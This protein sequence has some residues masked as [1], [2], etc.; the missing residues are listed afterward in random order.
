MRSS[1]P[2]WLAPL[3]MIDSVR[4]LVN[5]VNNFLRPHKSVETISVN[6]ERPSYASIGHRLD[7]LKEQRTSANAQLMTQYIVTSKV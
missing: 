6:V 4:A 1:L 2:Q 7:A 3:T 5:S